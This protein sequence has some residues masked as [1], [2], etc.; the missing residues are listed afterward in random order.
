M[1]HAFCYS[2]RNV[3]C[4]FAVGEVI[5]CLS[6]YFVNMIDARLQSATCFCHPEEGILS[7]RHGEKNALF[8]TV[9]YIATSHLQE[10]KCYS[11]EPAFTQSTKKLR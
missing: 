9:I 6:K 1:N 2:L 3:S 10:W 7:S 11:V 4:R 8:T 5:Q